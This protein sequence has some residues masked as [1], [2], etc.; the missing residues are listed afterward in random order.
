M[1]ALGG[2][3][4]A[5]T[6]RRADIQ[7]LRA[8]AVLLV[9]AFHAD[10]PVPGGFMGVDVF[11]AISGFVITTMLL[12]ELESSG[13]IDFPRFYIRRA[14][15]LSALVEMKPNLVITAAR[16]DHYIEDDSITLRD[17]AGRLTRSPLEKGPTLGAGRRGSSP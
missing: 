11:F 12:A 3:T 6:P 16:T 7:G 17:E 5:G 14:R 15:P 1:S 2:R 8:L 13:R 4:A 10:L 9:V